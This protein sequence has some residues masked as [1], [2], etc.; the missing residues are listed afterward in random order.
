R[1]ERLRRTAAIAWRINLTFRQ[2]TSPPLQLSFSCAG[3]FR[4]GKLPQGA[5]GLRACI[6]GTLPKPC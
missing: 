2:P 1:R 4:N 5:V 6:S 3:G